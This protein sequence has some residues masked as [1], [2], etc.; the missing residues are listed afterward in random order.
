MKKV[1]TGKEEQALVSSRSAMRVLLGSVRELVGSMLL[2]MAVL[3]WL[4]AVVQH[5]AGVG[6]P[7][8]GLVGRRWVMLDMESGAI[9]VGSY[10]MQYG[11][12]ALLRRPC[13]RYPPR[14]SSSLYWPVVG[15]LAG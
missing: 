13:R 2:S 1:E 5:T 15:Q 12:Q 6:F 14:C 7:V 11:S 9:L 10:S 3:T 4:S 8:V